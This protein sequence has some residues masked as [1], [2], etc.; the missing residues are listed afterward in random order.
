MTPGVGAG[1]AVVLTG[2][3]ERVAVAAGEAVGS[4]GSSVT[5][6]D[7]VGGEEAAAAD[8]G[9]AEQTA[10]REMSLSSLRERVMGI[11]YLAGRTSGGEVS[12]VWRVLLAVG[13]R[14]PWRRGKVGGPGSKRGGNSRPRG[15]RRLRSVGAILVSR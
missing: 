4:P 8:E 13:G 2:A 15:Q 5:A 7:R 6:A 11:W 9:G 3:G 1:E 10:R 12:S 14:R